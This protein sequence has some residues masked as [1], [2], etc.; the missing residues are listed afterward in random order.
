MDEDFMNTAA[1]GGMEEVKLG[2][3]AASKAQ[4]PEVK[5][6][7]QRMV[8]DHNKANTELKT[9]AAGKNFTL[10]TDVNGE[11]KEDTEKL[12]KLTGAAFDKEYVKMMVEDHEKDV[13]DFQKQST[14]A[15]DAGVKAFAAKTLPTL[16]SHLEQ[17]KAIEGKMK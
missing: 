5:A 16:K 11:Q 2:E 17:I 9:L 1:Q 15:S 13:A 8:T 10:P 4:S 14:G 6:F 3:L 7:G 12:S